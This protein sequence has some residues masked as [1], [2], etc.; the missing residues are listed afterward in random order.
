MYCHY[1]LAR[2]VKEK[3]WF[4]V[5]LLKA[6]SNLVFERATDEDQQIFEFFVP[7]DREEEFLSFMDCLIRRKLVTN[8]EK[9]SNRL[10]KNCSNQSSNA[11]A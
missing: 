4:I 2:L 6:E 1:Y 9:K 5:G 7:M 8:L 10:E 3:T 11:E